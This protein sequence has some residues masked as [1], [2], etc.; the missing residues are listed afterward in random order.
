VS[1]ATDWRNSLS[2]YIYRDQLAEL[3]NTDKIKKCLSIYKTTGIVKNIIDLCSDFSSEGI[4]FVHPNAQEEKFWNIWAEKVRLFDRSE[5]YANNLLKAGF[6]VIKRMRGNL[7]IG[8]PF[9]EREVSI[10]SIPIQYVFINPEQIRLYGSEQEGGIITV[11]QIPETVKYGY[12]DKLDKEMQGK[13][14]DSMSPAIKRAKKEGKNYVILNPDNIWVDFFKKDDWQTY[15]DPIHFAA[16]PDLEFYERM[17]EM[18]IATMQGVINVI[19]IWKLGQVLP[20]GQVAK[21]SPASV[22]KL[23]ELLDQ[24]MGGGVADIIWDSMINLENTY[25][26]VGEILGSQKY[27]YIKN[28]ILSDF[29]IPEVLISGKGPGSFSNQ[30]LVLRS[31]IEKLEYVRSKI[32]NWVLSEVTT[33][34]KSLGW[35]ERP[36]LVF[37]N[38]SLRDEATLQRLIIQLFDR[39]ILSKRTALKFF[40]ED[41]KVEES[42]IYSESRDE[43]EKPELESVGPFRSFS[44]EAKG[45]EHPDTGRK[46]GEKSLQEYRRD[47]RPQGS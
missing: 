15:P 17:R 34:M 22:A 31:L 2:N 44:K 21:P 32:K 19:R 27:E 9:M 28:E 11:F 7:T 26:P 13:L 35:A 25:P 41:W 45:F 37:T 1:R 8:A 38:M 43:Q 33:I 4:S 14:E 12:V 10:N 5:R 29:G 30:F 24:T 6:V 42:A 16:I 39:G 23:K 40:Y 46:P 36:K 47:E 3:G 20:N 18:D